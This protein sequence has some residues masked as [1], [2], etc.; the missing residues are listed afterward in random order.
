MP[1]KKIK[2]YLFDKNYLLFG[3]IL[4]G[5]IFKL[6]TFLNIPDLWWDSASYAGYGNF[7]WSFGK[8]GFFDVVRP[9]LLPLLMGFFWKIG[10]DSLIIG[11][12]IQI[13][14]STISIYLV[15]E[16][17][18]RLF[19]KKGVSLIAAF[20]LAIDPIIFNNSQHQLT[21]PL[22]MCLALFAVLYYIKAHDSKDFST[23]YLIISGVFIAL[24]FLTRFTFFVIFFALLFLLISTEKIKKANEKI[25][26]TF[27][28]TIS[29][30]M[31]I[32]PYLIYNLFMFQN[33]F[34]PWQQV[35][36][37]MSLAGQVMDYPLTY[38]LTGIPEVSM[39]MIMAVVGLVLLLKDWKDEKNK[40]I[41]LLFI[42]GFAYHMTLVEVKVLRYAILFLPFLIIITAYGIYSAMMHDKLLRNIMIVFLVISAFASISLD[43][44]Y[45]KYSKTGT[46]EYLEKN[47]YNYFD[48]PQYYGA[49]V[50]STSPY[51]VALSD[52][53]LY[54]LFLPN[55][56]S[57]KE[58]ESQFDSF[59]VMFSSVDNPCDQTLDSCKK[60]EGREAKAFDYIYT[61]Y[62]QVQNL[63][64]ANTNYYI[65]KYER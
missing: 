54:S 13:I 8:V 23:R 27:L 57:L 26:K 63:T 30:I 14:A 25:K 28:F 17:S 29:A 51:P 6:L 40:I 2:T 21:E 18:Q 65:F 42:L 15:Y 31:I 49:R 64:Y 52:V 9:P 32:I 4:F 61:N 48:K 56:V 38:Y 37:E 34:H 46:Q 44:T 39:I 45:L 5:L 41:L 7:F 22:A 1:Y 35:A 55:T 24:S 50:M 33:I 60:N 36:Y 11:T 59:Y 20:L 12:L 53:R 10:L 16:I 43:I 3:I 62:K 19:N 58:Y 47:Y